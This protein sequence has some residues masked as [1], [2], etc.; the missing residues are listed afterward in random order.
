MFKAYRIWFWIFSLLLLLSSISYI[1]IK[2][3]TRIEI[4]Q[5]GMGS[6]EGIVE[7]VDVHSVLDKLEALK[8]KSEVEFDLAL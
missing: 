6:I 5:K 7:V 1:K 8:L 3:N 4:S 2:H